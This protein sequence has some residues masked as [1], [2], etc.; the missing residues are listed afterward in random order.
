[1]LEV[2]KL[3]KVCEIPWPYLVSRRMHCRTAR[4]LCV[5]LHCCTLVD[6]DRWLIECWPQTPNEKRKQIALF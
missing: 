3:E 2:V 5:G 1:M 4:Y 6:E